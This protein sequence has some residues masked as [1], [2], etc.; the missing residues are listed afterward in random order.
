MIDQYASTVRRSVEVDAAVDRAFEV[1]VHMTAW[2]PRE[3]RV[4]AAEL[5]EV[6]IEPSVGGRCYQI[7]ADG[8]ECDWGKVQAWDPPRRLQ[9][10]WHLD[11]RFVFDPDPGRASEVDVTFTPLG[12]DRTRVELEHRAFDRHGPDGDAIRTSVGGEGGWGYILERYSAFWSE[13]RAPDGPEV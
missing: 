12:D 3:H 5:D 8:A 11:R 2:W 10:A 13:V 1:F 9:I 4:V 7:G 6:V